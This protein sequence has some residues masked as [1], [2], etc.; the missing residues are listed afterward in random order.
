MWKKWRS[1]VGVA[2]PNSN[3]LLWGH[4]W[5]NH[6]RRYYETNYF[7]SARDLSNLFCICYEYWLDALR[8]PCLL[9]MDDVKQFFLCW[10]FLI[11]YFSYFLIYHIKYQCILPLLELRNLLYLR[12]NKQVTLSSKRHSL[13]EYLNYT[14]TNFLFRNQ[15]AENV[16]RCW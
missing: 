10:D 12:I 1:E 14:S 8:Y 16:L 7:Y 9:F 2:K 3:S 15:I 6:A 4:N 13:A 11:V 5:V